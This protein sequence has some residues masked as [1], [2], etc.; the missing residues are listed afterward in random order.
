MVVKRDKQAI[1]EADA[2]KYG[3]LEVSINQ[4]KRLLRMR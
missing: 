4:K 2:R 3:F 1:R